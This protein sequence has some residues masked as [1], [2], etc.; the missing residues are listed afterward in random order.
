VFASLLRNALIPAGEVADANAWTIERLNGDVPSSLDTSILVQS[1]W[2]DA[3]RDW[4]FGK[5]RKVN[6]FGWGNRNAATIQWLLT[7]EPITADVAS[8]LCHVFASSP[9]P[10]TV[11]DRL[12]AFFVQDAAKKAEF[13][14]AA[15]EVNIQPPSTLI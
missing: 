8:I 9:Y 1:G 2:V 7:H 4:V 5:P 13:V 6:E 11:C 3:L 14:A 10:F 15:A 12:R